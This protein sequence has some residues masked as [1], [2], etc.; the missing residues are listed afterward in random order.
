M[1]LC[2]R[3][4]VQKLD[5]NAF[6]S[7]P[8]GSDLAH[9]YFVEAMLGLE[10]LHEHDIIHRDL[11]PD[12]MLITSDNVLKITD[13]GESKLLSRHG[14]KIKGYSG[15]PAFMAPELCSNTGEVSGEAADVWSLGVCLYSFIYGKLPFTGETI[16]E[17]MDAVAEGKFE[18]PEGG[19]EQL[20]DLLARMLRQE[21]AE[22][23]TIAEM[24]EHTWV[25]QDGSYVITAKEVNCE[26]VVISVTQEDLDQV[27][28]PIYDI[29][30][31]IH[32]VAKLKRFRRRIR[33]RRE[34]E[35]KL[36]LQTLHE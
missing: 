36:K 12:N 17:I 26:H 28:Q 15:T 3:G 2:E 9:K 14:E 13:F 19:D 32:A 35:E 21:P 11:K 29:M 33:E 4:T 23:I 1:D 22:R 25:T 10:Y 34:L 31:V 24:R 7:E 20:Q 6:T 18:F 5:M 8:L 30:P 27:I 16:L